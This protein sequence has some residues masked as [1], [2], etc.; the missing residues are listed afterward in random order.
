MK[1]ARPPFWEESTEVTEFFDALSARSTALRRAMDGMRKEL[2]VTTAEASLPYY[3][4][5]YGIPDGG[6]PEALRAEILA[7]IRS[8]GVCNRDKLERLALSHACG[9]IAVREIPEEYTVEITF[10]STLGIPKNIAALEKAL[11]DV[12][13][14]HLAISFVY[15]YRQWGALE[16]HT[17]QDLQSHT[18]ND[19][20]EGEIE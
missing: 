13:P 4:K 6:D 8:V 3:A 10:L 18:W 11:R 2:C 12:V 5:M 20:L 14:A 1:I 17:W 9:E 15:T 19:I 7:K 16:G